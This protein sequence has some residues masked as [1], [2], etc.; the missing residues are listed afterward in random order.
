MDYKELVKEAIEA[1]KNAYV[2][3]SNFKVG[4]AVITEDGT[5]YG[6]CNIENASYG[7]ANCAERT[8][9]F[10][11]ISEGHNSIK[12]IAVVGDQ[13]T[14]TAPCGICRQVISEFLEEDGKIIVVKNED[15]YQIKTLEE[16]LPGAFTKKDL[17]K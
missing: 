12:A 9:I 16:I 14:Y 5:I 8:A 15:D 2:P 7:A 6:G 11:A 10:K 13:S 17:I 3:Y 1:R 4:A